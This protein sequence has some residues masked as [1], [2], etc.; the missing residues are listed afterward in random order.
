LH[1]PSAIPNACCRVAPSTGRTRRALSTGMREPPTCSTRRL[2]RS[3]SDEAAGPDSSPSQR[4]ATAG[5]TALWVTPCSAISS[6]QER[7][8]G[9]RAITTVPPLARVP[10]IPGQPSG[11]LCPAGSA[12]RYTEVE[13]GAGGL[14][15]GGRGDQRAQVDG[16]GVW[17]IA[18]DPH[19][20]QAAHLVHQVDAQPLVVEIAERLG[21]RHRRRARQ[22]RQ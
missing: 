8:S 12:T 13:P 7:G 11:K 6:K 21:N 14:R 5:T 1:S 20:A 17:V 16:D 3:G 18:D 10:R 9:E 22:C 19:L 2:D 4:W 15:V